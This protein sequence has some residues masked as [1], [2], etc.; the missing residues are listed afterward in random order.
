MIP[1]SVTRV[2]FTVYGEV[3]GVNF[4]NFT[5][6]K[7]KKLGLVGYVRNVDDGRVHGEAQ[8]DPAVI[9]DLLKHLQ[10]GPEK[11]RVERIETEEIE[12]EE[13]ELEFH[14]VR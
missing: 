10:Q 4:R 5:R 2:A 6:D 9:Q 13:G 12:D 1:T 3:Q 8:G 7:A 11:A 14:A